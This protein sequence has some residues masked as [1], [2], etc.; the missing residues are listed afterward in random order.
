M[1]ELLLDMALSILFRKLQDKKVVAKMRTAL[2][3][4]HRT[5]EALAESDNH[6]AQLI[7]PKPNA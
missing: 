3:K 6:L 5:I 4:V 1:E 7:H 2:A